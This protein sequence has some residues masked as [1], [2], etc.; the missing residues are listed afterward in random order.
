MP[1]STAEIEVTVTLSHMEARTHTPKM[2]SGC[3]LQVYM[4]MQLGASHT[5]LGYAFWGA[6]ERL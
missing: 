6:Q 4:Q 1:D 2:N 3:A 5:S